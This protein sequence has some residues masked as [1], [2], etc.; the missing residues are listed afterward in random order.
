[1]TLRPDVR[2]HDGRLLTSADVVFTFRS[3]LDPAFTSG[4]KGAYRMVQAVDAV[5][6]PTVRFTLKEPFASFPINLVMGI[7]PAGATDLAGRPVGSG[8][9]VFERLLRASTTPDRATQ[10]AL[11]TTRSSGSR[12]PCRRSA[13]G[14]RPTW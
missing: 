13:C 6:P 12:P 4:R 1:M 9:Y 10:R 2:F 7:V 14:T 3:F 5:D 8:P 11:Y